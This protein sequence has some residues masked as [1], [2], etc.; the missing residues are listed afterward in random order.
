MIAANQVT[1]TFLDKHGLPSIRRVV[2]NPERWERIVTMA[3]SLG[4]T[5]PGEPDAKSLEAF[6]KQQQESNPSH[7]ADLSLAVIKLLG[8][9]EYVVKLPG[10][11]GVGHFGLAVQ[12]YSHST[13]PNRRYPDLITQRLL[14]AAFVGQTSPYSARDLQALALHCTEKEDDASKVERLVKKC[15]AATMLAS[16]VGQQFEAVV[17]GVTA[18]GAWLRLR[19]PPVDGKLVGPARHIDVGQRVRVRLVSVNPEKGFIDSELK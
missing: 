17:S 5:L 3:A 16:R 8:R 6:L 14:K 18:D 15:A 4:G 11:D 19:H 1:A 7:S 9:G 10:E 12:N 2:R 13:A